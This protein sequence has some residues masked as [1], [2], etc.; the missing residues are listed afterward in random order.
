MPIASIA[1][2]KASEGEGG[3]KV[4]GR[5][6]P[7]FG[8]GGIYHEKQVGSLCAVHAMNNLLQGPLFDEYQLHQVAME[9]DKE[10]RRLM[11][12][13][14]VDLT[15]NA[16]GDGFFNIQV[17]RALLEKA[18]YSIEPVKAEG[19]KPMIKDVSKETGFIC[20]K[21]EH[22]FAIRRLGAEWFDLNSCLKTPQHYTN[23]DVQHHINEAMREGYMVFVVRGDYP[24]TR[25]EEDAKALLEAVQGCGRPGQGHT[26]FAGRGNTLS[27]TG[28]GGGSATSAQ[29]MRAARLARLAGGGGSTVPTVEAPPAAP[30]APAAA[31]A[32][33]PPAAGGAPVDPALQQLLDMGFD[34]E[35][36]KAALKSA[37]GNAEQAVLL[38]LQ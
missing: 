27:N 10:E 3:E 38:L 33:A 25:L 24:R 13:N 32:Q 1:D 23:A 9:L 4:D 7:P 30:P 36:S 17:I 16:R 18:Q 28:G 15:G 31:P 37:G 14:D 12:G 20:N 26:L 8:P 6:L 29:D 34:V 2:F 11:G 22:W 21:R 5:T 19:G 35:K